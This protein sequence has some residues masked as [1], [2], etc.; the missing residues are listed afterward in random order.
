MAMKLKSNK[1]P[2]SMAK[3]STSC[4]WVYLELRNHTPKKW[5]NFGEPFCNY[6][7][8]QIQSKNKGRRQMKTVTIITTILLLTIM[9][10]IC[11]F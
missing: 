6:E 1:N 11:C 3:D 7:E 5:S 9:I 8:P 4:V 2:F 10:K